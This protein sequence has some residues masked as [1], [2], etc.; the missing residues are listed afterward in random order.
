M[1]IFAGVGRKIL[2][3][4]TPL[5]CGLPDYNGTISRYVFVQEYAHVFFIPL[6]PTS[7]LWMMQKLNGELYLIHAAMLPNLVRIS[8]NIKTP[9]WLY[10]AAA[11]WLLLFVVGCV[12][13]VLKNM[14]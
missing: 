13:L 8:Q 6:F 11:G 2:H 7:K 12:L 9:R 5:Q 14:K 3:S 4:E 10:A 1:L